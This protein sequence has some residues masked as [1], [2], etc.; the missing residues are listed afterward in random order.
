M[1]KL[2]STF[3][4][5]RIIIIT[6]RITI[7]MIYGST[8]ETIQC[9]FVLSGHYQ[10]IIPQKTSHFV[11]KLLYFRIF[12]RTYNLLWLYLVKSSSI[13]YVTAYSW[14]EYRFSLPNQGIHMLEILFYARVCYKAQQF[15]KFL[16]I[17]IYCNIHA[18]LR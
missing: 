4:F 7:T 10:L 14:I 2:T 13:R 8:N 17:R 18:W 16:Y 11:L 3:V 6:R 9:L 5:Q 1:T 15:S 12:F